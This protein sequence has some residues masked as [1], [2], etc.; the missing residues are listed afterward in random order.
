MSLC[1]TDCHIDVPCYAADCDIL[2]RP[3]GIRYLVFFSCDWSFDA[4]VDIDGVPT[5]IGPITDYTEWQTG[6]SAGF[7]AL[8]PEGFGDKPLPTFQT[9]RVTACLP[10]AIISETH[11]VNF[12]SKAMDNTLYTDVS[13]WNTIRTNY[14]RYTVGYYGCD[15]LYYGSGTSEPGFEFTPVSLGSIKENNSDAVDRYEAQLQFKNIGIVVPQNIPSWL[16]AFNVD[17][18]S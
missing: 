3:S 17:C 10:E 13:Y 8:S 7:I 6:V 12:T 14:R 5:V 1:A 18:P 4:T 9:E 15:E 2:T 16:T 11:V